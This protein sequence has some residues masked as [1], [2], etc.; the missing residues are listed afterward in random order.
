[1]TQR[2]D[3]GVRVSELKDIEAIIDIFQARGHMRC[4]APAL[5][6]QPDTTFT[7]FWCS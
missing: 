1:M 3:T 2:T 5:I 7:R 6:V 4:G